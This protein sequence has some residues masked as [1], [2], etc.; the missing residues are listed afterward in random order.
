[1]SSCAPSNSSPNTSE[2]P[3]GTQGLS[4]AVEGVLA[5]VGI[6]VAVVLG[7]D[8]SFVWPPPLAE[9]LPL[10]LDAPLT[11][12]TWLAPPLQSHN[13]T[14]APS[15][16]SSPRTSRQYPAALTTVVPLIAHC[17]ASLPLQS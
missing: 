11:F 9:E 14:C 12:H 13:S 17:C 5:P 1:M 16:E 6:G 2:Y 8:P 4:A 10:A 7:F 3:A 15:E